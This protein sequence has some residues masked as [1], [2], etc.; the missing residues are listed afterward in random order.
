MPSQATSTVDNNFVKGLITEATGLNFPE[1]AVTSAS[2]CD[3]TIIGDVTRRL[4]INAEANGSTQ[5]INRSNSA[6]SS[7]VWNNPGGDGNSKIYVRQIGTSLYFYNVAVATVTKPLSSN[8]L[9]SSTFNFSVYVSSGGTFDTTLECSFAD[10]NGYLVVT[11]PSCDPFYVGYDPVNIV[12]TSNVITINIRDFVGVSEPALQNANVAS[13][14]GSLSAEHAYNLQ[15]QGWITGNAWVATTATTYLLGTTGSYNWTTSGGGTSPSAGMLVEITYTGPTLSIENIPSGSNLGSGA[16][17]AYNSG[18]G[19]MTVN[20]TSV[21]YTN[22]APLNIAINSLSI[23]PISQG[24]VNTFQSAAGVYPSNSDVWWYYKNSSGVFSPSTTLSNVTLTL[25]N[26]PNGHYVLSAFTQNK[27][28]ISGQSVTNVNTTSRPS[29]CA[30]YA[31]RAWYSGVNG[32]QVATGDSNYYTWNENVYFSQVSINNPSVLGNCYQTNDPTSE[33]L[34]DILPTDGGVVTV[35]ASGNIHKL[36]PVQNG[37]LVFAGN[38]VWFITGSQGIGF[39]A[40]DYTITK[41]SSVKILSSKSFVDVLGLP[42]FWNE[43]GIYRVM[44]SQSGSMTVEPLTVGTIRTFYN[45]IPLSSRKYARGDYDPINYVI[46]WCY[47]STPE[48]SVT[49]RYQYDSILNFNTYNQSFFPYLV[50][51][52]SNTQY[53]HDVKYVSYPF[54]QNQTPPP[55]FKYAFSQVSG[56]SYF[57]GFAGEYDTSYMDW[58]TLD[59]VSTFTTGYKLHGQA[60]RKFQ[61]PYI[62][63][64]SRNNGYGAFYIQGVWDYGINF[65]SNRWSQPQF[66]ELFESNTGVN[67]RRH[68]IRGRG[69]SLQLQFTSASGKSFDLMG[70]ALFDMINAGA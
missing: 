27:A 67:I 11:H 12:F 38:G 20:L 70:W 16:I 48:S 40:N 52:G 18:T 2:N 56:G 30:W 42:Y 65:D 1:N 60:W 33:N 51:T 22:W 3:F 41:I 4:G 37:L 34:F 66:V 17:T 53:I 5:V 23:S 54:I 26:A 47:R 19:V 7:Y 49:D 35:Y 8:N 63:T 61:V 14:P 46:Q 45:N 28:S 57:L 32:N 39:S 10:G 59:Y 9:P 15:N 68:K 25:G 69:Y 29:N 24:Y 62:L 36:W 64:Y 21:S 31:G 44:P 58:G 6:M 55:S 50:S 13:R 43:E